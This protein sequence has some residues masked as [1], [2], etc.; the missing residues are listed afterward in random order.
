VTSQ[1]LYALYVDVYSEAS[2][3]AAE[4]GRRRAAA[5]ERRGARP[6]SMERA[7]AEYALHDATNGTPMRS[8]VQ[9]ERS[10]AEVTHLL[11]GLDRRDRAGAGLRGDGGP[12]LAWSS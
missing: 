12:A 9:F 1:E 11:D 10:L 8:R 4:G 3:F 5:A 6:S 7:I 2:H